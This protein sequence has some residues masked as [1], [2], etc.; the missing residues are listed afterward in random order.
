[1]ALD[2]TK[3]GVSNASNPNAATI[4]TYNSTDDLATINTSGYFNSVSDTMQVND[5]IFA[6][7]KT[8]ATAESATMIVLSNASG[9]VD[10]SDGQ[11]ISR[12]D[13]D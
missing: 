6:T 8:N 2:K 9:V 5:V 1:M 7:G 11:S 4:F 3:I 13:S 12:T 10:V